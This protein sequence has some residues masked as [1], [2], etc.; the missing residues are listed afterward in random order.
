MRFQLSFSLLIATSSFAAAGPF[1][2]RWYSRQGCTGNSLACNGY[3]KF[4]CCEQPPSP[5]SFPTVRAISSGP[6]GILVFTEVTNTGECGLCT[7]TGSLNICYRNVPFQTAF[8]ANITQCQPPPKRG[9][10]LRSKVP[11]LTQHTECNQTV[12][13]D[14][15]T[16]NGHDYDLTGADRL[17]IMADMMEIGAVE[18]AIKWASAHRGPATG[19][20]S[21]ISTRLGTAAEKP[22]SRSYSSLGEL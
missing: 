3:D 15:A 13:L 7:S 1:T 10:D 20:A 12:P 4:Q 2:I 9:L 17:Q 6:T 5:S 11:S 21:T 22:I 16:V 18:F 8:V 19:G 14:T